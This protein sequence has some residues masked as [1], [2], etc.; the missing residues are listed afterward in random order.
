[1]VLVKFKVNVSL[2][3]V[4]VYM[5]VIKDNGVLHVYV[6]WDIFGLNQR[7]GLIIALEVITVLSSYFW[8]ELLWKV[9]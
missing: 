3:S 9:F 6:I 7:I 4:E 1:M 5:F 8:W 2:D